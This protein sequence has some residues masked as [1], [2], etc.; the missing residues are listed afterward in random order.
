MTSGKDGSIK[1]NNIKCC[2]KPPI[3]YVDPYLM[4]MNVKVIYFVSRQCFPVFPKFILALMNTITN[5]TECMDSEVEG[6]GLS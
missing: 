3:D 4:H 6:N 5:R 1:H 2:F